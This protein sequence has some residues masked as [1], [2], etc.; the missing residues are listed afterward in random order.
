MENYLYYTMMGGHIRL[1]PGVRPHK[2]DC[3]GK[4]TPQ[5]ENRD[6]LQR[7]RKVLE[8]LSSKEN[9]MEPHQNPAPQPDHVDQRIE[10]DGHVDPNPLT[11]S[12]Q[13]TGIQVQV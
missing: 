4:I 8:I 7:K 1:H 12:T 9:L 2:F 11:P 6:R 3:Q 10:H 5:N 13:N